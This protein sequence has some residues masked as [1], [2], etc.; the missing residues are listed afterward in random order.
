MSLN[1]SLKSA[2]RAQRHRDDYEERELT[3]DSLNWR[4]GSVSIAR[5]GVFH[6]YAPFEL[7]PKYARL[8]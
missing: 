4:V 3:S 1:N 2:L 5:D 7:A 6:L 8:S